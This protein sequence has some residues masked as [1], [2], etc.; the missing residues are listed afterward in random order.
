M[1]KRIGCGHSMENA[2]AG[3]QIMTKE[4]ETCGEKWRLSSFQTGKN[5]L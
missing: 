1:E 2:V 5:F 3:K 4:G